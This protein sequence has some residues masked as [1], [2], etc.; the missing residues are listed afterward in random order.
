MFYATISMLLD[1]V[2]MTS[3]IACSTSLIGQADSSAAAGLEQGRSCN[4]HAGQHCQLSFRELDKPWHE[5][6]LG[7][8][9]R[10][11]QD[12]WPS[13]AKDVDLTTSCTKGMVAASEHPQEAH[14]SWSM[15]LD[16][17]C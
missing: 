14:G 5:E 9:Y 15:H 6:Q 8:L 3:L 2:L 1:I 17:M 10:V 7:G 4:I 11:F 12:T 13:L 16:P